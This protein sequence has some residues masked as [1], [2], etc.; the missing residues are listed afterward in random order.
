M[1][2]VEVSQHCVAKVNWRMLRTHFKSHTD[3][4]EYDLMLVF[5]AK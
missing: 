3:S 1:V 2:E 5:E 4:R